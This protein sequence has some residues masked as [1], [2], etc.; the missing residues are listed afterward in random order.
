MNKKLID[1]N[2]METIDPGINLSENLTLHRSSDH[3]SEED[4]QK[5]IDIL[6]TF[7]NCRM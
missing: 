3:L 5:S 1:F 7:V 6:K 4:L 2:K